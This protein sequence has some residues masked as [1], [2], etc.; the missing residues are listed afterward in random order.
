M[1]SQSE[2][3]EG[4]AEVARRRLQATLEELSARAR[5]GPVIDQVIDYARRGP[6]G[7]LFRSFGREVRENPMPV[8][9]IGIAIAWLAVSTSR[10]A[11]AVIANAA[12]SV[13]RKAAEIGTATIGVV[14]KT[15]DAVAHRLGDVAGGL[16]ERAEEV[17]AM[18]A[19]VLGKEEWPLAGASDSGYLPAEPEPAPHKRQK[20]AV[21]DRD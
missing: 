9:L 2:Q 5:L 7:E 3:L 13:S 21:G 15:G 17:S 10:S 20:A 12:D 14:G 16:A 4:Q 18:T 19:A 8:V 11:R 1:A 6:A